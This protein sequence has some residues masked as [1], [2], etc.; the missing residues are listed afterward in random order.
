MILIG[1]RGILSAALCFCSFLGLAAILWASCSLP[2]TAT[3][4][5]AEQGGGPVWVI[6][7]GHGGEDGGAVSADGVPESDLNLEIAL[8]LND[9]LHFVGEKTILTREDANDLHTEGETIRARK[10]S[11][12]RNRVALVNGTE[13]AVLLSIHQN[14]LPSSPVTRGAQ[15]FRN[16]QEGGATLAAHL[17]EA[18]NCAINTGNEKQS[19]KIPDTIYLMKH[20]TAPAALIECG[21]L[22]NQEETKIL[23]TAAHQKKLATAITAGCLRWTAG[24]ELS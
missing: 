15:V 13:T 8:R 6:D 2:Y 11:D 22:S 21:F 7:A 23:Q 10:A 16:R 3:F 9:F 20:V 18:L 1:K 5:P 4:A 17:Q 14:S 24:E 19:K 12:V